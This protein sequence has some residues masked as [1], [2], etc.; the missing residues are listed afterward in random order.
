MAMIY[1]VRHA[2]ASFGTD[3]YDRLSELGRQQS[4][5]LGEYFA[6]RGLQFSKVVTGTLRRQRETA[7]GI[8]EATGQ[9]LHIG[10]HPGLDE[11]HA[12]ALYTAHAGEHPLTHQRGDYKAYWR[13]F[14]E[15]MLAWST[16][17]LSDVPET[18][19]EFGAR[20]ADALATAAADT[21]RDDTVL[22]V[23][24]GGAIGRAVS[25][26]LGSPPAVAIELNLQFRNSGFCE[27][28][29]GGGQMRLLSYNNIPHLDR[30]DRRQAITFA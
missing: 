13:R 7:Q 23:S 4:R 8:L 22:L 29:A 12:E 10:T 11:Y 17:A 28:I 21:S 2:Q 14:R 20:I 19:S 30:A 6:D 26:L 25:T 16:D 18:W 5:W 24:S 27:L 15:A 1:L 3:D 9:S